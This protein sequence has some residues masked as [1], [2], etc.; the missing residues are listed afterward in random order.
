MSGS[1]SGFGAPRVRCLHSWSSHS[2]ADTGR[3][4]NAWS[5][6][7]HRAGTRETRDTMLCDHTL[8]GNDAIIA[9]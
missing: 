9:T 4:C 7:G 6:A 2:S 3:Y 1:V 8:P 5:K